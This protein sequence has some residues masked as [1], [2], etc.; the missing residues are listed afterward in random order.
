MRL[1]RIRRYPVKA[2]GGEWLD[3]VPVD[4]RGLQGDRAWAVVDADG[5]FAAAKDSRRFRRRDEVFD[6][7]AATSAGAVVITRDEWSWDA[8]DPALDA[9]LSALMSAEVRLLP[10]AGISHFDDQPVSLVGSATLDH[11]A[12]TRG[13]DADPRRFRANLVI[14]TEEPFVEESWG[15]LGIDDV[16][17]A[18]VGAVPR[19]RATTIAQDGVAAEPDMLRVL[20]D[21]DVCLCAYAQVVGPGTLRVGAQVRLLD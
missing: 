12:R 14:E 19:C 7:A 15:R 5:R 4:P 1:L 21:R 6:F 2:M 11:L 3:E 20:A 13:V 10:E 8:G 16:E 17:L 9:E 18:V